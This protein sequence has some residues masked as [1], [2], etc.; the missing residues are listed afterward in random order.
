MYSEDIRMDYVK[1]ICTLSMHNLLEIFVYIYMRYRYVRCKCKELQTSLE[2]I[3]EKCIKRSQ[4]SRAKWWYD[5]IAYRKQKT[6]EIER[7]EGRGWRSV[8]KSEKGN[9]ETGRNRDSKRKTEREREKELIGVWPKSTQVT[10]QSGLLIL[11][12]LKHSLPFHFI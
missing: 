7:V 6:N 9:I 12:A 3:Y 2:F 10:G 4:P 11:F 8:R 5:D 1:L